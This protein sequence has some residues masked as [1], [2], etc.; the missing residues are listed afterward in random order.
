M[1]VK[2]KKKGKND[3]NLITKL[4]MMMTFNDFKKFYFKAIRKIAK[5]KYVSYKQILRIIHRKWK[6]YEYNHISKQE[7]YTKNKRKIMWR[8]KI[9]DTKYF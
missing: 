5:F 2:I 8:K 6:I 4:H 7:T 3:D 9:A 1:V